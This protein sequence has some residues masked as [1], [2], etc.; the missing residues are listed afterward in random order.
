MSVLWQS[1]ALCEQLP[2]LAKMGGS[3]VKVG[4]LTSARL[5][6][7]SPQSSRLSVPASLHVE[8]TVFP[9]QALVDSGAED[10]F[11]DVEQLGCQLEQ[12][13]K[14]I[15]AVALDSKV[16][17]SVTHKTS[18]ITLVMSVNHHEKIL[19][20]IISAP[21]TS[22]VLGY[23]WLRL[24][25]PHIDWSLN[26]I[27]GWST[28]CHSV[29]LH[30]ALSPSAHNLSPPCIE[31]PDLT[32][33]PRE[34]HDLEV[35]FS[36]NETLSLPAHR[37][38]NCAIGLLP[39][40]PLPSGRLYNLSRPEREAMEKYISDSQAAEIIRPSSS[41]LGVGF[42]LADKKDKTL[43]PCI[44]FRG[45]NNITVKNKYPQPLIN[46]AFELLQDARIFTKLDLR[47][48]YHLVRIKEG[49]E[50][51][52]ACDTPLGHYEYLVM[53]FGLTNAPAVFQALINDV[54]CDFLNHFVF[55]YLMTF[56]NFL[57]TQKNKSPTYTRCW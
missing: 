20:H 6:E 23:S 47:N 4:V 43:R 31:P 7:N 49:D 5:A 11:L 53:P 42:F 39:G 21:Q 30:S 17:T 36:K 38:Y 54:L 1:G 35:V 57:E 15:P 51:K 41:P 37:P 27:I 16:F 8:N 25:N 33:E 46:S 50:W 13:D 12:L 9:L 55:V 48:T 44:D 3:S 32:K 56:S 18:P 26:K 14:P 34:Y 22:L 45:L 29:C 28:Q 40:A 2:S 24:H 19:F 10:N 52:T